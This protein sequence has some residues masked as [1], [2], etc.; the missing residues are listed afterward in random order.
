MY[1]FNQVTWFIKSWVIKNTQEFFFKNAAQNL[2]KKNSTKCQLHANTIFFFWYLKKRSNTAYYYLRN[3]LW[4]SS[5]WFLPH[6][7]KLALL[8]K[9]PHISNNHTFDTITELTAKRQ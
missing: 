9:G 2:S 3:E 8:F 5:A 7:Y 6:T 1:Y 4:M